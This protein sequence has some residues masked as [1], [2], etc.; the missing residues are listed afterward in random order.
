[1]QSFNVDIKPRPYTVHVGC[2]LLEQ[3]GSLSLAAGLNGRVAVVTDT[4]V[5]SLYRE[6]VVHALKPLDDAPLV[7]EVEPGERSKSFATLERIYDKLVEARFDRHSAIVALGGGVVGDLAGFAAATFLRGVALVQVPTSLLA[8]VDSALGG[9]TAINHP[10]GKNLIGAFY[11]PALI[12]ADIAVLRSLP[13]REFREGLAEVIKYAAI[14]DVEMFEQLERDQAAILRR[15][16]D[17]LGHF[18]TL[19][20]RHK[21]TIVERDEREAGLRALLNFGHTVGHALEVASG[22][23]GLLHG[24]AVAIGMVA[25][26]RLSKTLAGLDACAVARLERWLKGADLPTELLPGWKDQKFVD[27]LALD[28]KRE[29]GSVRL[30]LL[31]ELGQAI[32]L[33]IT[34]DEL[35]RHLARAE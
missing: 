23:G 6:R 10:L 33:R 8:Q 11:Q 18:V 21:A 27:A 16:E 35:L 22:F 32:T 9:K 31:R 12:A 25:E 20:L 2:G 28:K 13:E 4:N 17:I 7:I 3:I 24:E 26:A 34:L 29:S 5:G 15:S 19:C 30:I 1:M 14:M